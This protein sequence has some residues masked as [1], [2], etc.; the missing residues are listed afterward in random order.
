MK[1]FVLFSAGLKGKEPWL[2]VEAGLLEW[3]LIGLLQGMAWLDPN[4]YMS[5]IKNS[6]VGDM[7][8]LKDMIALVRL[9][10]A[11]GDEP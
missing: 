11:D 3:K 8:V 4:E 6:Q 1:N 10:D 7:L 2:N 5:F 9:R